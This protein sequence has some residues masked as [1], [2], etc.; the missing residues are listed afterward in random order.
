MKYTIK[1]WVDGSF[2]M[3]E[4][5]PIY[6]GGAVVYLGNSENPMEYKVA[7]C[8][9]NWGRMRNV[10]GELLAVISVMAEL[11]KFKA[12]IERVV[13]FYDYAGIE[14]WITGEW[15]ANKQCTR[16]YKACIDY[17]KESFPI[18]FVKVTAHSGEVNNERA[19]KLAKEAVKEYAKT[20]RTHDSEG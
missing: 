16:D 15:R 3:I 1:V 13:V 8:D 20:V 2:S 11:E 5:K 6:G 4:K 18:S 12:N 10:A 7:G 17:Y 14:K 19:D 9:S